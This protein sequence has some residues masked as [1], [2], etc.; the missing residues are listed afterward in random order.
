[1]SDTHSF[2]VDVAKKVGVNAAILLQSIKWWCQKNKANERHRHDGLYWTYNSTKALV[3]LYPYLGKGAI[4]TALKKLEDGGYIRTGN[5]NKSAYDRT[6]W[7]AITDSGLRL[8]GE[9]IY[10]NQEM[11]DTKTGNGILETS[12]PIPV[13][14]QLDNPSAKQQMKGGRVQPTET[15][16]MI[17]D[18][19]TDNGELRDTLREFL[20]YRRASKKPLTN[21]ALKLNLTKLS[22]LATDADTKSAIVNQTIERGWTGFFPLKDNDNQNG[23]IGDGVPEYLREYDL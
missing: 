5:Y 18:G 16:D 19:Y 11:E 13:A 3:D 12:Q 23:G 14:D 20:K 7:Y 9:S 17:I 6:K 8:F 4:N 10:Q 15:L 1:M 22:K 21:Q 2:N